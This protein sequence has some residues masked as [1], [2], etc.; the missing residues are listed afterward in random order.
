MARMTAHLPGTFCWFE[1]GSADAEAACRF[2][3]PLFGWTVESIPLH[4]DASYHL[5]KLRGLDVAAAY[6]LDPAR[7]VGVS[8]H[9]LPYVS[10]ASADAAADTARLLGGSVVRGPRDIADVGRM[11]LLSDPAGAVLGV[12]QAGTHIGAQLLNEAGAVSWTELGTTDIERAGDFYAGLFVWG[13]ELQALEGIPYTS[14]TRQGT[15]VAGMLQMTADRSGTPSHWM[16]YFCV[17]DCDA[18]AARAASLGGTI[19]VPPTDV[20]GIGRFA[21]LR[22]GQGAPFSIIRLASGT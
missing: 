18:S 4:P 22:D 10:V 17:E 2:Y 21:T 1:L 9:W 14:F 16:L 19:G 20:P 3:G 5:F 13:R 8:S 15:P 12:W 6:Q 11:T 7:Q